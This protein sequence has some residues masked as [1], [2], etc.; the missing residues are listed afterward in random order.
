MKRAATILAAA[1]LATGATAQDGGDKAG[2]TDRIG[3]DKAPVVTQK[4]L[5]ELSKRKSAAIA[6][7]N[8]F[9][10]QIKDSTQAASTFEGVLRKDFAAVKGTN[11]VY[12]R[13]SQYLVNTGARF[14]PPDKL[15]GQEGSLA[16]TFRNPA[17]FITELGKVVAT[18]QFGGEQKIEGKDCVVIDFVAPPPLVKEYLKEI[19]DRFDARMRGR[20]NGGFGGLV[21]G[22]GSL[23]NLSNMIDEKGTM[24]TLHIS[25][26]K[27]D[28]NLYKLDFYIRPKMKPQQDNLPRQIRIP[29]LDQKMEI[30]FSKWDEE[31]AFDIAP[32]IRT[33]WAI[34]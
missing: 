5:V 10:P 23:F 27:A 26:G 34:R 21:G 29:D 24:A 16:M 17:L 33:K 15:E 4:L 25:V 7:L 2:G 13:G 20:D 30:K 9:G 3:K 28:L 11:E 32:F 19:I 8:Y 18:A 14:D 31:V 1:L 22:R 6:E 12:A